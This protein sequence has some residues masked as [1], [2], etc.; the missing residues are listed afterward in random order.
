VVAAGAQAL[1]IHPRQ[2]D[3]KQS[4]SAQDI[5]AALMAI[6]ARCPGIAIG[7]STGIWIEPD[8]AQRLRKVQEWKVL[9]DFASVNFSEA[10]ADDLCHALRELGIGIEAGI[11]SAA[12]VPLLQ[13]LGLREQCLRIL[14]E[15][16][17]TD[18]QAALNNTAEIIHAL[19]QAIVLTPRLLH[20]VDSTT[21]TVLKLALAHSYDTRIGLEDT[22]TL[23]DGNQTQ[24][25]AELV[26]A[27]MKQFAS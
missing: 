20:G 16:Q 11:S 12:E 21:W 24:G 4:L 8:V 7:V 26:S 1:H 14:I 23:P 15:P 22:L 25:N 19:N 18:T 2:A 27:V 10:G 5:T 3:G 9:P 13:K 6:R 17:E